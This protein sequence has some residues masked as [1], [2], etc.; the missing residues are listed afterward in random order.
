MAFRSHLAESKVK[1]LRN[2]P[3][4]ASQWTLFHRC[5][6][7]KFLS[8]RQLWSI[9]WWWGSNLEVQVPAVKVDCKLLGV[10]KAHRQCDHLRAHRIFLE[11]SMI[12]LITCITASGHYGAGQLSDP[13]GLIFCFKPFCQFTGRSLLFV[14]FMSLHSYS[15]ELVGKVQQEILILGIL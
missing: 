3:V 4:R 11:S 10:I 13:D 12:K 5:N 2:M 9:W 14:R 8:S 15:L 1:A 6:G 7:K